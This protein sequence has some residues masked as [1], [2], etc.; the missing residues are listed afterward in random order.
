MEKWFKVGIM[1]FI[2][3]LEQRISL[4]QQL[5]LFSSIPL[6]ALRE[7][8][9]LFNDVIYPAGNVLT[10]ENQL[11]DSVYVIVEG[12][13]EVSRKHSHS[14]VQIDILE[15]LSAGETIGLDD[16]GFFS[17]TSIRTATVMAITPVFA[18]RLE[19]KVL[20]HF[21][22]THNDMLPAMKK[23]I[24]NILIHTFIKKIEPFEAVCHSVLHTIIPFIE[25]I[26]VTADTILFKQG[27]TAECCYLLC[28]GQVDVIVSKKVGETKSVATIEAGELLGEM[29]LF[30]DHLRNATLK[31]TTA[32]KLLVIQRREFQQLVEHSVGAPSA[33]TAMLMDR[34]RPLQ[35]DGIT[36]HSREDVEKNTIVILKNTRNGAYVKTSEEGLFVWHLLDG[37]HTLQDIAVA[38]FYRYH[39]LAIETI[40]NL[41]LH[42]MQSGFV[43]SPTLAAYV[44]QPSLPRWMRLVTTLRHVLQYEYAI[45]N[46]DAWIT[47]LY[48]K[49]G[50][51]FFTTTAKIVMGLL[52]IIGLIVFLN[53]LPQ[54]SGLLKAA[55]NAWLLIILVWPISTMIIPLH[56]LAHALTT[57][58]YGYQVH[59]LGVGWFWLG[60]IAFAD[61]SDM[62]LSTRGPRMAVNLAGIFI[63]TVISGILALCAMYLF[64][65]TLAVFIWL[66][67]LSSYLMAFYNLDPLF[68]LDGYYVLMDILDKP[69]LRFHAIKWLLQ[70]FKKTICNPAL[71]R[72]YFPEISYW[73]TSIL[74]ILLATFM[75]YI[76]QTLV[77]NNVLP[78]ANAH[79]SPAHYKWVLS[80]IVITLSFISLYSKVKQQA[81]LYHK[82]NQ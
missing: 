75:A 30:T 37:E 72:V 36:I 61:T 19:L 54:V 67:A 16:T 40:G 62:W 6:G 7:L 74:F 9:G 59:R 34:H 13:A 66:V 71:I 77:L 53:F 58:A 11:I 10:L 82:K 42:L 73:L 5:E 41:V 48:Q 15:V 49:V 78:N 29:A 38:Y 69:N 39:K 45:T 17:K 8:A 20:R 50:Y 80:V 65:G 4:L 28:S 76:I 24:D 32:C 31:T 1:D 33:L 14:Q 44:P 68:E 23:T 46:V 52:A 25:F 3:S 60:P 35:C 2:T 12:K 26:E 18:M 57:K 21:L 79:S 81:Y 55:P 47:H 51:L 64:S 63:N 27:D 43:K 70:D 22:H 56:E